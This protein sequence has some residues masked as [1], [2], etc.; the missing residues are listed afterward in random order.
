MEIVENLLSIA[1]IFLC[2]LEIINT[3]KTGQGWRYKNYLK[4]KQ[5]GSKITLCPVF[6]IIMVICHMFCDYLLQQQTDWKILF[7]K[8]SFSSKTYIVIA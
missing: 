5:Q 1:V 6:I 3:F 7:N 8:H 2:D 4:Q